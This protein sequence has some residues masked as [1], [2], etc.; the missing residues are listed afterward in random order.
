MPFHPCRHAY[1]AAVRYG[2]RVYI[3]CK[4]TGALCTTVYI[5]FYLLNEWH[6]HKNQYDILGAKTNLQKPPAA[7]LL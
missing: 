7:R 2:E 3:S 5:V 6:L 1:N 4:G